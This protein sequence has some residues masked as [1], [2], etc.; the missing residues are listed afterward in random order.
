MGS[1]AAIVGPLGSGE[2]PLSWAEADEGWRARGS[3][4]RAA[5]RYGGDESL[6]DC[7]LATW[8]W[9]NVAVPGEGRRGL[10]GA[11]ELATGRE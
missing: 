4:P 5:S 11:R 10:E 3:L 7:G 2:T 9:W 6:A 1:R 8:P